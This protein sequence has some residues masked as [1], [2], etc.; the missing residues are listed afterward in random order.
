MFNRKKKSKVREWVEAIG[1][2]VII[3]L[4]IRTFIVQT[5][6]IPSGSMENTLLVGDQI[7]VSK[8]SYGIQIPRP[9]MIKVMGI[10]VPFFKTSLANAWGGI[11]RGDVIVFAFPEG[12]S[13]CG[14]DYSGEDFIKRAIGLPGDTVEIKDAVV[15]IN[16]AK[17]EEK[18]VVNKGNKVNPMGRSAN[19][20]PYKVPDGNIFAMG[21]NRDNSCDSRFWGPVPLE[22]VR[23]RALIIHWSWDSIGG[24]PRFGRFF[25]SVK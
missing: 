6:K 4:V 22:N 3:A 14:M 16:G 8:F 1:L 10:P 18:F 7:I 20:G 12:R 24:G 15:Y 2:A 13:A 23:G 11:E 25:T 9:A 21:D 19:F 17:W 5:F